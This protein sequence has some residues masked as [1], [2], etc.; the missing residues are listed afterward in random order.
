MICAGS[1]GGYRP[2]RSLFSSSSTMRSARPFCAVVQVVGS[3]RRLTTK[4][5]LPI[6]LKRE[7]HKTFTNNFD[8]SLLNKYTSALPS[9]HIKTI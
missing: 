3:K 5:H 9:A 2:F 6:K 7:N 8:I 4:S 1:T